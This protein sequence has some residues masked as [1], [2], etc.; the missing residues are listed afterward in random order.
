[1]TGLVAVHAHPDD[2]SLSTGA[3]L[4]TWARAGLPTTVV[5]CTRGERGEVIGTELGHLEGDGPALAAHRVGELAG[6]LDALGV[7][8]HVFLDTVPGAASGRFED[9]GM[10]WVSAG[11]AGTAD[12]VPPQA[13][14]AADLEDAAQRLAHLLRDRRAAVVVTY[15]PGGGYGHPDHVRAHDVTR[16]AVELVEPRPLLVVVVQGERALRAGY[17]AL[18]RPSVR[19]LLGLLA[20]GLRLPDADGPLP[21]VARPDDEI[22][23]HVDVLPVRDQIVAALR[24]HGTQVQAVRTIDD[25]RAVAGCYALSNQLLAPLLP[26]EAYR[27]VGRADVAWP[28][29]VRQIA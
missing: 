22:D 6:A 18:G 2:E 4:A 1:M 11:Q 3:L 19:A 21:S 25:D 17:E 14:V 9:S 29:G 8:D 16:R 10:A 5:T 24:A 20:D 26:V 27:L 7:H 12:E 15:E 28:P 23:L 13:F